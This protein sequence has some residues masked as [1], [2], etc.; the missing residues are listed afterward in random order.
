MKT[1]EVLRRVRKHLKYSAK[2]A[3]LHRH[4]ICEAINYLYY[5][6]KVIGDQDRTR[7]KRIVVSMLR[8]QWSLEDWLDV[9]HNIKVTNTPE[10]LRKLMA[11]RKAWLTHLIEFYSSKGD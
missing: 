7:V 9:H 3:V 6:A 2:Y 11:T 1:S 8:P 5:E 4:F 10:Y